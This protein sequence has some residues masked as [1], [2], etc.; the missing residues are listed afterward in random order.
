MHEK[1]R[2]KN[3]IARPASRTAAISNLILNFTRRRRNPTSL[4]RRSF[5]EGGSIHSPINQLTLFFLLFPPIP[6]I[7]LEAANLFEG[8]KRLG[9]K[10]MRLIK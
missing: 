2:Q 10:E 3:V 5:S 9:F 1:N 8:Q 7:I 4:V 6:T